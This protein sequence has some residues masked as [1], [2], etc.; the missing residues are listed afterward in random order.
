MEAITAYVYIQTSLLVDSFSHHMYTVHT[1]LSQAPTYDNLNWSSVSKCRESIPWRH[2]WGANGDEMGM[3]LLSSRLEGLRECHKLLQW[4]LWTQTHF[5]ECLAAKTFPVA[6]I[7]TIFFQQWTKLLWSDYHEHFIP[8]D[9]LSQDN[10]RQMTVL[11]DG[12]G[13]LGHFFP[14]APVELVPTCMCTK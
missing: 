13:K 4:D 12:V 10:T 2:R 8:C 6:A 11:P 3:S 14:A 5:G 7:F 9:I 1:V